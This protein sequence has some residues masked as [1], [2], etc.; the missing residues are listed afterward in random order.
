MEQIL[1]IL[2]QY[3]IIV[4]MAGCIGIG[5]IIKHSLDFIPN[6]YIPL[7]L[8]VVG[9]LLNVWN[10]GWVLNPEIL[11]SGLASGLAATGAFEGYKNISSKK[12]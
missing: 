12:E 9:I 10:N 1:E 2:N 11:I 3:I 7:I 5:Y 8:G 4:I 6:K